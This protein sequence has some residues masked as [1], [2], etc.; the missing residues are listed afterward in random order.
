M[1][2]TDKA[3]N[4]VNNGKQVIMINGQVVE[5]I[6]VAYDGCHKIYIC[7]NQEDLYMMQDYG[8]G[9]YDMNDLKE[10]YDNACPLKFI[11][12]ADLT[13]S[14]VKQDQEAVFSFLWY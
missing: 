10:I 11:S 2:K 6:K 13:K 8:Y 3:M 14:Y 12:S 7:E 9:L 5:G 4:E 1:G